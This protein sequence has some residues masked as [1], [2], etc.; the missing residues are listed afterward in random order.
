MFVDSLAATIAPD[1]TESETVTSIRRRKSI[2]FDSAW[3][4]NSNRS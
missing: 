1:C 4:I 2:M 3:R